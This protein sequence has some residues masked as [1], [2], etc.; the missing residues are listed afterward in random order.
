MN[1]ENNY[2][3]P[4]TF[5]S[6]RKNEDKQGKV[7]R[8]FLLHCIFALKVVVVPKSSSI[9]GLNISNLKY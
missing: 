3:F 5:K 1:D 8:S 6:W 4:L 2:D 9:N 7:Q